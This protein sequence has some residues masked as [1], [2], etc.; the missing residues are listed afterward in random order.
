M[1]DARSAAAQ[2]PT[3]PL[4]MSSNASKAAEGAG[5]SLA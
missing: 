3:P 1:M 2:S 4:A 5:A